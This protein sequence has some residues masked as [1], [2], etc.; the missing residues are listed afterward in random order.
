MSEM[1]P[2]A[3]EA[4]SAAHTDIDRRGEKVT[5]VGLVKWCD[6][7]IA[8][9]AV[10]DISGVHGLRVA[11]IATALADADEADARNTAE[12]K[13]VEYARIVDIAMTAVRSGLDGP[14]SDWPFAP[15]HIET[16]QMASRIATQVA[17]ALTR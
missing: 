14:T 9:T 1:S 10:R 8:N 13:A 5:R 6:E 7:K 4:M 12:A 16:M 17:N 11:I 2:L 15:G 3:R